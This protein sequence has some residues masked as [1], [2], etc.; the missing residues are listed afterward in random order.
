MSIIEIYASLILGN[1]NDNIL[2]LRENA[3]VLNARICSLSSRKEVK[4]LQ[5]AFLIDRTDK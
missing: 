2:Q 1:T 3:L 5:D 4:T